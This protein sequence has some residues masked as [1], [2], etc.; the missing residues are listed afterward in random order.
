MSCLP[1]RPDGH[2]ADGVHV[3]QAHLL[4]AVPHVVGDH[5]AVGDR[6]GVGH[7]E[8]C[9][10]SPESRCS[11]AGIDVLGVLAARLA[12]VGVQVDEAGQQDL[13]AGVDHLSAV[14]DGQIRADGFD[15][16]VVDQHVDTVTFAVGAYSPEN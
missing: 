3:D 1:F 13:A 6:I 2:R 7:R 11:R 12:Q 10:V 15:L 9:R 8:H 4:T 14:R 5:R 16:A